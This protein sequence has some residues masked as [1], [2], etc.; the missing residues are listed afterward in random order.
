MDNV[1]ASGARPMTVANHRRSRASAGLPGYTVAYFI[2][3]KILTPH[4]LKIANKAPKTGATNNATTII[5]N[6]PSRLPVI[7][8]A[9]MAQMEI[10]IQQMNIN[11][12]NGAAHT[13]YL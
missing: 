13:V 3:S 9:N 7:L 6:G 8:K 5:T 12:K 11:P 1:E 4:A 10:P 2:S